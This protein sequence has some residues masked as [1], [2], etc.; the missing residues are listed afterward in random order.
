MCRSRDII[1]N[2]NNLNKLFKIPTN[3]INQT[4]VNNIKIHND[5]LIYFR[6]CF[7]SPL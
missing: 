4:M 5:E 2:P 7:V 6:R 1:I 3:L